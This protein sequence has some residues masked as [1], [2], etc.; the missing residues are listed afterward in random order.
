MSASTGGIA[1]SDVVRVRA[2][3]GSAATLSSEALLARA[4]SAPRTRD[5]RR[6]IGATRAERSRSRRLGSVAAAW[7]RL[8]RPRRRAVPSQRPASAV[9]T[10]PDRS[11]PAADDQH[12]TTPYRRPQGP[13]SNANCVED[14]RSSSRTTGLRQIGYTTRA[15][16]G[17][18]KAEPNVQ[19]RTSR[20]RSAAEVEAA[21]RQ[22]T[23]GTIYK[24]LGASSQD[25][26]RSPAADSRGWANSSPALRG[27]TRPADQ[28]RFFS[29][30]RPTFSSGPMPSRSAR[31]AGR[32]PCR[33]GSW[34]R[35]GPLRRGCGRRGA[36]RSR[37][38]APAPRRSS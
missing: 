31:V 36:T 15:S 30:R 20:S 32:R 38:S 4:R 17:S 18:W 2:G 21:S 16:T 29:V 23:A 7:R 19:E 11:I 13:A 1:C 35:P 14:R 24:C 12:G 25:Q 27:K 10:R 5:L 8:R 9:G 6:W 3:L 26:R 28:R 33:R 22:G 37:G 34:P